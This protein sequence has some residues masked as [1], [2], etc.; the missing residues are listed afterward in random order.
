MDIF[1]PAVLK[2][3]SFPP[4]SLSLAQ[5]FS[6]P[7]ALFLPLGEL[8]SCWYWRP[9]ADRQDLNFPPSFSPSFLTT[10]PRVPGAGAGMLCPWLALSLSP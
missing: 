9:N 1:S 4:R 7:A 2:H 3:G 6:C 10:R 5:R 8:R